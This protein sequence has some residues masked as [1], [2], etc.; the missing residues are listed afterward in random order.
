VFFFLWAFVVAL[1]PTQKPREKD[2]LP[3]RSLRGFLSG[4]TSQ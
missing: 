2:F 3:R 1:K 4:P